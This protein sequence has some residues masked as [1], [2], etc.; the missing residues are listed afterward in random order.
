VKCLEDCKF[1]LLTSLVEPIVLE[2]AAD[3]Q[4]DFYTDETM[5]FKFYV[6]ASSASKDEES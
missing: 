2:D 1:T 3:M 4:L 6:P 5:L